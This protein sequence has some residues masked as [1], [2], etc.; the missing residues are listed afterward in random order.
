MKRRHNLFVTLVSLMEYIDGQNNYEITNVV[1]NLELEGIGIRTYCR[2][3]Y[4]G[5]YGNDDGQFINWENIPNWVMRKLTSLPDADCYDI[6][7]DNYID[8]RY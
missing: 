2:N 8:I 4:G 7:E 3:E 6:D 5:V 1:V